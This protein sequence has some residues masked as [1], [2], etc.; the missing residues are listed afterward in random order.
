[1]VPQNYITGE[2][3]V[4]TRTF[5]L[6]DS[7]RDETLGSGG[8]RRIAVRLYYPVSKESAESASKAPALSDRK[9]KEIM[10]FAYARKL[11]DEAVYPEHY[12]VPPMDE[13]FPLIMFSHG[14][15]SYVEANT[16]LCCDLASRGYMV[17]SV[18]HANEAL[19]NEYDD[20]GSDVMDKSILKKMYDKNV[21]SVLFEMNKIKK[22][23]TAQEKLCAF[24]RFQDS[25]CSFLKNRLVEWTK[26]VLFA[27]NAV[28]ESFAEHIDL[29]CGIG[30]SGHSFGGAVAYYLCRY[31]DIFSCGIN[32]DG[33]MWG[34]YEDTPMTKP[35]CQ[36]SCRS[37]LSFE[38]RPF[39]DTTA[40]TY[41]VI[42]EDMQHIGFADAKFFCP[43]RFACGKLDD[44]VL[45]D[46]LSY[47]HHAFFDK[48][49]KGMD[50][51]FGRDE[52][53]VHYIR[54]H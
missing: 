48:Y 51:S 21:I 18:G 10:K 54:I 46:N 27:E 37:N 15:G 14:L 26:D 3:A 44:D 49:L 8:K 53:K 7:E 5:S 11:P 1:M 24:D 39:L 50:R 52:A 30:V 12:D 35:F 2:Y 20:G 9:A 45:H 38:T 33:A 40:D 25:C 29:S 28:R 32:I 41:Q 16:F 6:T 42:F 31:S 19:L 23:K 34:E 13:R 22:Y 43:L 4:G 36:I 47:S 17:A